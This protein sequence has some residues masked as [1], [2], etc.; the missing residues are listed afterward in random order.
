VYRTCLFCSAPFPTNQALEELPLGQ[1]VA[2]DAEKGRLW[3]VCRRCE[4]WSLVPLEERWEAVEECERSYRDT[5][6]RVATDNI[7]LA[8][9]RD[10][11]E[12]VRIGKPLRPEFAAWRY[13]DQFGRRRRRA[14]VMGVGGVAA[15]GAFAVGGVA[16][17]LFAAAGINAV[18]LATLPMNLYNIW[19]MKRAEIRYTTREGEPLVLR[20]G[21]IGGVRLI[22]DANELILGV[23]VRKA[24]G[25]FPDIVQ[26]SGED[27]REIAALL[28]PR[29][30]RNGA[31]ASRV[32][33]AVK[34][35]DEAGGPEGFLETARSNVS[36]WGIQQ[37]WGDSGALV[38]LPK[39]V[40][41]AL[42]MSLHEEVERAAL[43]GEL[44]M[45]RVAWRE[46][47]EVAEIA[48]RLFDG[49]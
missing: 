5:R 7:G 13:G 20:L 48:D 19:K 47:E 16:T 43:E 12:L 31:G 24:S 6:L 36:R 1:R 9:L 37:N 29:V 22:P 26:V 45:L 30:N 38:H 18:N 8:R 15:V 33:E 41:L 14:V 34:M 39:P 25:E 11:T 4:R 17:G 42:E 10:G 46:A 23:P 49:E 21:D 32:R 40:Q 3:V 28:M 35:L 44:S 2:F 27:A